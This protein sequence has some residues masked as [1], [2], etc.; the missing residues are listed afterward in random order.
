MAGV[1]LAITDMTWSL[2]AP[3]R[4]LKLITSFFPRYGEPKFPLR[5]KVIERG[6]MKEATLELRPPKFT[7]HLLA[8]TS[9]PGQHSSPKAVSVSSMDKVVDVRKAFASAMSAQKTAAGKY[10]VW[11]IPSSASSEELLFTTDS[12]RTCGATLL[13]GDQNNVE[14]E[15]VDSNEEFVV[16]FMRNDGWLVDASDIRSSNEVFPSGPPPPPPP[17]PTQPGPLFSSGTDFFSQMETQQKTSATVGTTAAFPSKSGAVVAVNKSG[18]SPRPK[19]QQE[20]G[21][22]GLGNMSVLNIVHDLMMLTYEID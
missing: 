8:D 1:A 7:V 13:E 21:T 20:P 12:L 6:I 3:S 17:P 14:D 18:P 9:I 19:V 15:L 16:E 22:M 10:R 4:L 2:Y 11:R 5:R